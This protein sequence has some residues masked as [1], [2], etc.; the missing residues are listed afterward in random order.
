MRAGKH[1]FAEVK[2]YGAIMAV[3]LGWRALQF[4]RKK[5]LLPIAVIGRQLSKQ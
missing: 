3:L 4:I 2:V 1:N 5:R